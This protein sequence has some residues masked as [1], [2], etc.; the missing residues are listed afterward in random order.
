[1]TGAV[2]TFRAQRVRGRMSTLLLWPHS[3]RNGN[4][5]QHGLER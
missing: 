4:L 3:G 1:V 2:L 5:E